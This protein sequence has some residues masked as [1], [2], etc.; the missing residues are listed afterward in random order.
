MLSHDC[1]EAKEN[2][3][4]IKDFDAATITRFIEYTHAGRLDASLNCDQYLDV[5]SIAHEYDVQS[6]KELAIERLLPQ[7][8]CANILTV[9]DRIVELTDVEE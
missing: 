9:L 2:C 6:L 4:E 3:I 8:S 7:L 5:F 1:K